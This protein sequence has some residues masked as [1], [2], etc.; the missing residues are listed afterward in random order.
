MEVMALD[1]RGLRA[2]YLI[3]VDTCAFL[4]LSR[5]LCAMYIYRV[6]PPV[7][8]Q[9]DTDF[10]CSVLLRLDASADPQGVDAGALP[11]GGY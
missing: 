10:S 9:L 4:Y 3:I 8:R 2:I 5:S 6:P 1:A 7:L 11:Q